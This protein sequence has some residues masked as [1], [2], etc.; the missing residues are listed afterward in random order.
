[1]LHEFTWECLRWRLS[2]RSTVYGGWSIDVSVSDCAGPDAEIGRLFTF[3]ELVPLLPTDGRGVEALRELVWK[4]GVQGFEDWWEYLDEEDGSEARAIEFLRDEH[5]L[6]PAFYDED[7]LAL[8]RGE[9][10]RFCEEAAGLIGG[11]S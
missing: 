10:M 4:H 9:I 2:L 1:M 5:E 7:R 11:G 3:R 8:L 6:A